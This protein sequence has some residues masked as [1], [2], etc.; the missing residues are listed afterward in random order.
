M[1]IIPILSNILTHQVIFR[2]LSNQMKFRNCFSKLGISMVRSGLS[3]VSPE[4]H[5]HLFDWDSRTNAKQP[6]AKLPWHF[7]SLGLQ[8]ITHWDLT[9][10]VVVSIQ[11]V[12]IGARNTSRLLTTLLLQPLPHSRGE[13]F[14]LLDSWCDRWFTF[15][16]FTSLIVCRR[17]HYLSME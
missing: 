3:I 8:N 9:Q 6:R 1:A 14:S 5:R 16:C 10:L 7:Y 11:S 4:F 15:S 12:N 17:S 13:L 2:C